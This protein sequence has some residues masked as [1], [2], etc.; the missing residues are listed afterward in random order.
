[1][2]T[3]A[4]TALVLMVIAATCSPVQ[5]ASVRMLQQSTARASAA[6]ISTGGFS[7]A[8]ASAEATSYSSGGSGG[9]GA[10]Q[11]NPSCPRCVS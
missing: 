10:H 9:Y 6:A 7:A 8:Y 1:M 11:C 2:K 3:L 5:A 4:V